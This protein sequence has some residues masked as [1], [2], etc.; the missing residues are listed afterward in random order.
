MVLATIFGALILTN[1][2]IALM[3]TEYENVQEAAKGEVIYNKADLAYDLSNRSRLMPPPL[4]I[5]VLNMYYYMDYQT[6]FNL[7]HDN[8][9]RLPEVTRTKLHIDRCDILWWYLIA[10]C[11]NKHKVEKR[12]KILHKGCYGVLLLDVE[13]EEDKNY[14]ETVCTGIS[15]IEYLDRFERKRKQ[16]IE[17][18]DKKLLKALTKDTL[19]CQHCFKPFL[20][21]SFEHELAS[22]YTALLDILSAIMFVVF[23]IA[24]IPLLIFFGVMALMD[25]VFDSLKITDNDEDNQMY[26]TAGFRKEYMVQEQSIQDMKFNM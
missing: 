9:F 1:L 24:L 20:K 12:W 4:N 3:T 6:F 23:P 14:G 8:I 5:V 18:N 11:S 16:K 22:P 2:L 25:Y 17:I 10:C 21:E 19:F 26:E 15:M 7:Q 13:D